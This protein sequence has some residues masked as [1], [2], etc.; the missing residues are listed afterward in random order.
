K[1][2]GIKL[3]GDNATL[4]VHH[5]LAADQPVAVFGEAALAADK[6]V[7]IDPLPG[8][9]LEMRAHPLAIHQIHHQD[10]ARGEGALYRF[11]HRQIVFRPIEIAE[12]V[13]EDADAMKFALA[14]PETTG[15]AFMDGD[16]QVALPGALTGAPDQV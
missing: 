4:G 2:L 1:P 9:R 6:M 16:W 8:A 11:E 12:R 3:I 13:A 10:A 14:E 7:L 5:N 15:I